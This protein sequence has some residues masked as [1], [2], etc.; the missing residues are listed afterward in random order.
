MSRQ[1]YTSSS[2]L[3]R[4]GFSSASAVCGLGRA[5]SSSASVCQPAGRRCGIGGFSSR[6]VCDLG[7]GQRISF[8][9]SCRSG[10]YG[11]AGVGRCGVAY[12]GGRFGVGTVV[13]FGNCG[14]YGGLGSFRGLGD[15]V[16]MGGYG[17]GIGIGLGGGRSEG[18]RGVSIHPELLKPLCVGVDP[19]E[20]QVRTHE[21]EQ[22]KN[23][24]NQFACFIDKVRLLEQQ[25]KVL[26]TKWELLQQYVLP[27]S[28]R[29][30]EPVFENFICNL[31]KQ[32]ECVLGERERL[33]NEERCLRDLVQEYKCKYEDEINKRT[34]AEN[35]FVVL[36]KDVDCLYLTKEEL[37][38]RV[39]LLR[40]Q[41]EFLK[42]IYAEERAQLDCQLCDTS[43]IVQMDNSRDLDME[44]IIKSVECCYEEIAQKSK[45]EVEAF[46]Q[47]RLEE[48][49]SSRGK[50]CDDLR[51][52]QSEIA[53][54]N[55]MIQKLQC[56]SDNVKKQI[57]ALQTAICDAEQRGDCALKDARQ[58]LID[59]QTALQQA[60]DKM[61]CLLRDYQELLN[62][63]LALD[64]EIATYRTLLEGEESRICTGNPVSVA[65]V[66]GGGTVG[67]C[68]SLSG[69]G[70]KCAVKTGG[71]GAGLGV[72]SSFGVSNAGFSTRSVDCL[73]RVGGGFG[74]RSAVS[75]VGREVITGAEG[76]QCAPGVA[77][78]GNVV[79]AGVEQC[80]PGAVIIPGPG[81][82]GAG[83]RYSTAVRVVRTTR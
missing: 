80:S 73:P 49:H 72:V 19:E 5:N 48:L 47:T 30:L 40:Q 25:N 22:I 13:G 45:A 82:C 56:E 9:G 83:S 81:V 77:N 75:C 69:I 38:V 28:R 63:K 3:G 32:L 68:R 53:E 20:C 11:G 64:I 27:A 31:R 10:V 16:A 35:E 4:R 44:G 21:K 1:C 55:R 43:V 79:C 74:A 76:V 24:N 23:L 58:K 36:K 57:A 26:T 67:E 60:K 17:G 78:L 14:G 46:Y 7:R 52:N 66:S 33:E 41:L 42:C 12:G 50:F 34:A 59:L 8:G 62:V 54:L 71:A 29:N 37:E 65:V 2:L 70:G 15:G 61:A 6:S 39:G 51:N 18:I